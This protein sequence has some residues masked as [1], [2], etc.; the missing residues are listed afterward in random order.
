M[1]FK[2]P[3]SLFWLDALRNPALAAGW[4]LPEWSQAIRLGRRLRLLG[5]LAEALAAAG[6]MQ[7][8]PAQPQR[9][10]RAEMQSSRARTAAL[11]WAL[12]RAGAALTGAP[13][14]LVLLKGAAYIG[15]PGL[16]FGRGRLSADVDILVPQAHI[17]DA[18]ARLTRAGWESVQLDGHDDRYYREW[19][20]EV[21][22]MRHP[23]HP[24]ELDLHHTI[25]PPV[26][27][28]PV[29]A[30]L[31]LQRLQPSQWPAWQVLHPVDQVLHSAAH[32]FFDSDLRERVRDL[33]DLDGL[34]RHF[35]RDPDFWQALPQRARQ[36]GLQQPLA[37]A[38]HFCVGWFGTPMPAN[39][40]ATIHRAGP[41]LLHRA[42][43]LPLLAGQLTPSPL[44]G[45]P[46]PAQNLGAH[47]VMAR[48]QV[49]RLP[50]RMLIPHVQHK[51]Q[52]R[53]ARM[54]PGTD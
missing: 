28:N 42:W 32:L 51:W 52:A 53:K 21:P 23:S 47:L 26:S 11:V 2:R 30:A 1:S 39:T 48:Y 41:G 24:I 46:S 50:L 17:D 10:L 14:P 6:Q 33:A 15:Q 4:G 9:L 29:D 19:S 36:L 5:R 35:G 20:H 13:Y 18:Q 45:L 54:A 34:L 44:D 43:L 37:L 40:F 22:P 3:P 16:P 12:D 49:W 31:L 38:V 27:R 8:V 7:A 25:V